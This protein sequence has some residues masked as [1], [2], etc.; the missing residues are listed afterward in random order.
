MQGPD[1]SFQACIL[2]WQEEFVSGCTVLL[3]ELSFTQELLA[4]LAA[5]SK[6]S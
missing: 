4:F 6:S 3:L 5:A 1:L 2:T